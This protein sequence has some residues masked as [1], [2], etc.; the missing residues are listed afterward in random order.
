[1][2]HSTMIEAIPQEIDPL[3]NKVMEA[4]QHLALLLEFCLEKAT[5]KNPEANKYQQCY[6]QLEATGKI[7]WDSIPQ[8]F[9]FRPWEIPWSSRVRGS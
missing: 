6:E 2:T 9:F 1:M 4:R 3:T 5:S 7:S 8:D